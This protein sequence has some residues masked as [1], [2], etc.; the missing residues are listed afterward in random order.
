[1]ASQATLRY[2]TKIKAAA[3]RH[4]L[5]PTL[6]LG[7]V[8]FESGGDPSIRN[9][10]SGATG[11]GQVMPREAGASFRDRPTAEALKDPD[12]NLEWAARILKSGLDRYGTEDKALAAYLGSIDA[13]G[14][15]TGA[16]DANGTGGNQYIKT[17]RARQAELSPMVGTPEAN[18][19]T[20]ATPRAPA[21]PRTPVLS[22]LG[23][24]PPSARAQAAA[25]RAFAGYAESAGRAPSATAMGTARAA[26]GRFE[27]TYVS[28][29]DGI[30][31]TAYGGAQTYSEGKTSNIGNFNHGTDLAA[32]AGT[33]VRAPVGGIIQSVYNSKLDDRKGQRDAEENSG[34]GGSVV[35][36]GDDGKT[37]HLSHAQYGSITVQ[38][39]QRVEAGQPTHKVGMSGNATGP[40]VDWEKWTGNV[41]SGKSEDP[42][43]APL[44]KSSQ[45]GQLYQQALARAQQATAAGAGAAAAPAGDTAPTTTA[46]EGAQNVSNS[47]GQPTT[48]ATLD[49]YTVEEQKFRQ[50][51]QSLRSTMDA[52]QRELSGLQQQRADAIRAKNTTA[53]AAAQAR[54]DELQ[55]TTGTG[56]VKGA[57]PTLKEEL[58]DTEA[59]AVALGGKAAEAR[60]SAAGKTLTPQEQERYAAE[61]AKVKAET[62]RLQKELENGGLSPVERANIES[63]I[64]SRETELTLRGAELE[65]RAREFAGG[66]RGR[67]ASAAQDEW[68]VQEGQATLPYTIDRIISQTDVDDATA[69]RLRELLPYELDKIAADVYRLQQLTPIEIS[70]GKADVD[71]TRQRADE[72][73]KLIEP[74]VQQ[75]LAAANVD[76]ATAARINQM[77]PWEIAGSKA[78]IAFR[79]AQTGLTGAQTGKTVEEIRLTKL[80]ADAEAERQKRQR[81]VE[82]AIR[83]NP[84]MT[85]DQMDALVMSQASTFQDWAAA[86][87]VQLDTQTA[88]SQAHEQLQSNQISQQQADTQQFAASETAQANAR[89]ALNQSVSNMPSN[90]GGEANLSGPQGRFAALSAAGA[91][92]GEA[93]ARGLAQASAWGTTE[94]NG[95]NAGLRAFK[96]NMDR[97]QG[98][99]PQGGI[100]SAPNVT[101]GPEIGGTVGARFI[102]PGSPAGTMAQAPP[103]P[104][105]APAP[106][107]EPTPMVMAPPDPTMFLPPSSDELRRASRTSNGRIGGV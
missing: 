62:A 57:I 81:Y 41:S 5:D 3:E 15:I 71:L 96:D 45:G 75:A 4:G 38:P 49:Y 83:A 56:G 67:A 29:V 18:P 93:A 12:T 101:A 79:N 94:L 14:N 53:Q 32:P 10:S 1:M 61:T 43:A 47:A 24:R 60:A 69:A 92:G 104:A 73:R 95:V 27:G 70:Q 50:K 8:D 34:W 65:Q 103:P 22:P 89:T 90:F 30:V 105:A 55:G 25:D 54:I 76:T 28:P 80:E 17:V 58:D 19:G 52:Y 40:H 102:P 16:V 77:L 106:P 64:A 36:K 107:P 9:K 99:G 97:L 88:R 7:V 78:D 33:V 6:L 72:I 51:A 31:T 21:G 59:N 42:M 91:F 66:A 86:R 20:P 37:H 74:R 35:I 87:R 82:D 39:G 2:W 26:V 68:A 85:Y 46:A 48:S 11:L 44:M 100:R 84:N 13:R 63:Q 23:R 98:M